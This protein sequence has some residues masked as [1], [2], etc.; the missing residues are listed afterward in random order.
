MNGSKTLNN[1]QLKVG[2]IVI[3]FLVSI[4]ILFKIFSSGDHAETNKNPYQERTRAIEAKLNAKKIEIDS[5]STYLRDLKR[6]TSQLSITLREKLQDV[7]E[8]L[9]FINQ[10][11][12]NMEIYDLN[13]MKPN[14]EADISQVIKNMVSIKSVINVYDDR[15]IIAKYELLIKFGRLVTDR[16][17]VLN[18]PNSNVDKI[19]DKNKEYNEKYD[20]FQL[21]LT[22]YLSAKQK[23]QCKP[24]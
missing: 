10:F 22:K 17:K 8:K 4:L 16:N 24:K 2:I 7:A 12:N 23:D 5:L 11:N 19:E 13:T 20:S 18:N 1:T 21:A 6:D 3:L 9:E 15:E 14:I